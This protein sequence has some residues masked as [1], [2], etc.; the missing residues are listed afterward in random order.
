MILVDAAPI[1]ALGDRGDPR[2]LG[3]RTFLRGERGPLVIPAPV[4]AEID[5][6][7]SRRFGSSA[8]FLVD[9]AEGTYHVECLEAH[10][11]GRVAELAARYAD[12]APGLADLSLVVLALRLNTRRILTFDERHFRAMTPLQGGAFELL[13]G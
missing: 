13:P 12:L 3:V 5:Y 8:P 2:R 4:T 11:Y 9:L 1:I 6:M 10:E 7:L